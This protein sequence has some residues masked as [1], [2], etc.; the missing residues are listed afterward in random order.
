M[1]RPA[2]HAASGRPAHHQGHR[3]APAVVR[4]GHKI[5][6]L[7]EAAGDEV[8]ELHLG[9]GAQP[10]VAHAHRS[11]DDGRLR[12]GRI[13]H[14]LPAEA[15]EQAFAGFER[16]AIDTHVLAEQDDRGVAL[17]LLEHGLAD[18]FEKR[19]RTRGLYRG[20]CLKNFPGDSRRCHGAR[21]GYLRAFRAAPALA[22]FFGE[23]LAAAALPRDF[24]T[25][26]APLPLAA[27]AAG[28]NSAGL[29]ASP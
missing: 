11:A 18:G 16:P 23:A 5:R 14:A 29:S 15:F 6:N 1:E 24:E 20:S 13:H 22:N 27:S 4:L 21:H 12:D 10:E 3:R 2:V 9:D 28:T 8:N 7:V 26:R 17:H 25:G 19:Y